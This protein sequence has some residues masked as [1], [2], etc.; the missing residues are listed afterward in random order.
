MIEEAHLVSGRA[1][2]LLGLFIHNHVVAEDD[3]GPEVSKLA[4]TG[5]LLLLLNHFLCRVLLAIDPD[6]LEN[7]FIGG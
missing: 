5:H 7:H 4:I 1:L 3:V 2:V 6:V